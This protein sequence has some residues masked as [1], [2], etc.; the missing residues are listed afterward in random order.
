[1]S[2][3]LSRGRSTPAMRAMCS[4]PSLGLALYLLV[5][6]VRADHAY[7]A[8]RQVVRRELDQHAVPGKDPDVVHPHLPRDVRQ[9]VVPVLELHPEHRVREWFGDRSL[10]LD[11]VFL[12]QAPVVP[13]VL[14]T[15]THPRASRNR[16]RL[17]ADRQYRGRRVEPSMTRQNVARCGRRNPRAGYSALS[18]STTTE[19]CGAARSRMAPSL[20]DVSSSH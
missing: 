17:E 16:L 14:D 7:P 2:T 8:P 9:H 10:D 11:G 12:R 18:G 15:P 13:R 6:R 4:F 20:P 5:P 3:R 19:S 1:M